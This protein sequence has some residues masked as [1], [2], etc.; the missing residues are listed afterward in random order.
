MPLIAYDVSDLQQRTSTATVHDLLHANVVLRKAK[1]YC[2]QGFGLRFDANVGASHDSTEKGNGLA[3]VTDSSWAGQRDSASQQG[4]ALLLSSTDMYDGPAKAH[5]TDW[6][7]TKV[8]LKTRSTFRVETNMMRVDGLTKSMTVQDTLEGFLR[9]SS[10]ALYYDE[11]SHHT[12]KEAK[13]ARIK[14]KSQS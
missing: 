4:Y 6:S 10:Y 9:S 3:T 13:A 12:V 8:K 5:F 1:E 11:T 7:S 2:R 14:K